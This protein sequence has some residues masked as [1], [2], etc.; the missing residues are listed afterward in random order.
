MS[1]DKPKK[2]FD[3]SSR[4]SFDKPFDRPFRKS[5]DKPERPSGKFDKPFSKPFGDKPFSKPFGDKPFGRSD[6]GGFSKPFDGGNKGSFGRKED[7][8]INV[9]AIK[10]LNKLLDENGLSEISYT[11]GS[12]SIK[13]VRS[14]GESM[15][16][17]PAPTE[18][19]STPV[20]TPKEEE[21]PEGHAV[22]APL[23]GT[24]YMAPTPGEPNFVN[25]GDEVK[26]GQVLLIIEAMKVMNPLKSPISGRVSKI[27]VQNGTPVEYQEDLLLIV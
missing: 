11:S 18:R 19:P 1:F 17:I 5:F 16:H 13:L 3:K 8:T 14:F 7:F 25:V 2:P 27:F 9:E 4:P 21:A 12:T 24:V 22:K 10:T 26:E 20:E 6:K 15:V 23:V